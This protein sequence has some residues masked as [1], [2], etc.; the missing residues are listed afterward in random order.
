MNRPLPRG[1]YR[2]RAGARDR[3]ASLVVAVGFVV[4]I[5]GVTAG[6]SALITSQL[7]G[8]TSLVDVRADLYAADA[9]VEDAIASLRGVI[10][11]VAADCA[12]VQAT[13]A[14][15]TGGVTRSTTNDRTMRVDWATSCGVVRGADGVAVAQHNV[16]FEAC[17][18]SP[19]SCTDATTLVRA[20]V[21]FEIGTAGSVTSTFVQSW[22]AS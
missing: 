14:P 12:G 20:Q 4:F 13:T 2:G 17:L 3:G 5:G 16:T 1:G 7:T 8:N 19:T 11:T 22:S 9:A 15:M 10:G 6:L 21:N 18:D